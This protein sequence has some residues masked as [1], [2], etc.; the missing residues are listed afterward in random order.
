MYSTLSTVHNIHFFKGRSQRKFVVLC[1]SASSITQAYQC[2]GLDCYTEINF[3]RAGHCIHGR[4][5]VSPF[6]YVFITADLSL[7]SLSF[8]RN[9]FVNLSTSSLLDSSFYVTGNPNNRF[10][11]VVGS[12]VN[13]RENTMSPS[14]S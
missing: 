6:V 13:I 5:N 8:H 10:G 1:C 7:V 3:P 12:Q 4:A 2:M 11:S 14:K 9:I